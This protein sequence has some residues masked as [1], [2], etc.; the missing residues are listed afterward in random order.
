[1]TTKLKLWQRFSDVKLVTENLLS[2]T[3]EPTEKAVKSFL[4]FGTWLLTL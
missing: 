2:F 3:Q 1:M 4:K